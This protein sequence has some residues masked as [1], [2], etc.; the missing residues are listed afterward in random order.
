MTNYFYEILPLNWIDRSHLSIRVFVLRAAHGQCM[1]GIS[2]WNERSNKN[3]KLKIKIDLTDFKF[4]FPKISN[5]ICTMWKMK[6]KSYQIYRKKNLYFNCGEQKKYVWREK[7][8]VYCNYN[9]ISTVAECFHLSCLGWLSIIKQL[10]ADML[11]SFLCMHW[12]IGV[13]FFFSWNFRSFAST[14]LLLLCFNS[15]ECK[16][17]VFIHSFNRFLLHSKSQKE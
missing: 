12:N 9:F 10:Y 1:Y 17:I 16:S 8:I 5:L 13:I 2:K 4:I 15:I 7:K 11:Q 3:T 6:S 14:L